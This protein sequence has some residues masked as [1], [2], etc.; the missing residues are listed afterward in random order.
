MKSR[1]L[2]G[3]TPFPLGT[4]STNDFPCFLRLPP[5]SWLGCSYFETGRFHFHWFEGHVA[6]FFSK[7]DRKKPMSF[8]SIFPSTSCRFFFRTDA[9]ALPYV[10]AGSQGHRCGLSFRQGDDGAVGVPFAKSCFSRLSVAGLVSLH[11]SVVEDLSS[12]FRRP[13]GIASL[14]LPSFW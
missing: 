5:A 11:P 1:W 4:G 2:V 8:R 12:L 6:A 7:C 9:S 3:K 14:R 13:G 10:C